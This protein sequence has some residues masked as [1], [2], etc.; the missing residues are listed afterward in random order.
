MSDESKS[1]VC[2]YCDSCFKCPESDCRQS[3]QFAHLYNKTDFDLN[4]NDYLDIS[5][6]ENYAL[7][8]CP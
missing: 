7:S 4:P 1:F 8:E 6:G 5:K 3:T 2:K